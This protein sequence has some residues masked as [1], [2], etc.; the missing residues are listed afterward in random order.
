MFGDPNHPELQQLA[1]HHDAGTHDQIP[2]EQAAAAV[3][4]FHDQ[5]DPALVQ[6]V[7]D[8]HYENMSPA[9]LQQAA[10]QLLARLQAVAGTSPEAAQLAQINPAAATPQQVAHMH[11][12]LLTEHPE[13][14]RDIL[15][16]SAATL[17]VGALAAFAARRYLAHHGR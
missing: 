14:M 4:S 16:G 15:I 1:E 13:L 11:R 7:T 17:A 12:F 9:Q 3:Q 8:Q 10:Q 2:A 5:A 6:Q